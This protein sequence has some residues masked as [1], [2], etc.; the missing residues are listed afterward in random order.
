MTSVAG[1]LGSKMVLIIHVLIPPAS[2]VESD[3]KFSCLIIYPNQNGIR[4]SYEP[5]LRPEHGEVQGRDT[6]KAVG[7]DQ[8]ND[9]LRGNS[10]PDDFISEE[11][12]LEDGIPPSLPDD[13]IGCLLDHDAN[14]ESR[15]A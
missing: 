4:H 11:T 15:V 10:H 13:E 1:R 6:S 7:E 14:K 5:V 3:E 2:R 8:C 9:D 12:L